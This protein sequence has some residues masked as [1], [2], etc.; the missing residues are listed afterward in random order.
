M[1]QVIM[2]TMK[3]CPYCRQ[4]FT[5]ME[6]LKK[7]NP[8]YSNIDINIIDETLNPDVASQYDYYYVPTYYV[9]GVKIHEGAA[10]KEIIRTVF[11]KALR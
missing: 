11:E 6:E 3:S 10:T 7:E 5:W 2:F 4:A 8:E 1:K 9:D